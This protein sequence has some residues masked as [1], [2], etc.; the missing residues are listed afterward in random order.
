MTKYF[1]QFPLINYEG[2]L[3]RDITRRTNFTK[4][5]SNNPMLYMPYTVKEGERPEQFKFQSFETPA[6][7][8]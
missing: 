7:Q 6:T 1:E 3:V 2:K 8:P 5:V 4:E